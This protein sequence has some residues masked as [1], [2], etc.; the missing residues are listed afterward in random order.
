VHVLNECFSIIPGWAMAHPVT[1]LPPPL[2][3]LA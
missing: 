1:H 3:N 2:H